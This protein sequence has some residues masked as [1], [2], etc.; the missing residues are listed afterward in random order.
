MSVQ[1]TPQGT[2]GLNFPKVPAPLMKIFQFFIS[3]GT[4]IRGGKIL[5]LITIGSKT[6]QERTI[7]LR[8]FNDGPDRWLIIASFGGSTKHPAWYVNLSKNPNKIWIVIDDKKIPVRAESLHG[9]E[10]E[11]YWSQIVAAAP[12]YGEYQ[13]KTDREIPVIRLTR[14]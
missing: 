4:K 9:A 14:V 5:D 1:L 6:G 13:I 3:L 11:K 7:P 12:G 10:R 8:Y 2:R